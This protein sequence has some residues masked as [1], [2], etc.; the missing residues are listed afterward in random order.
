VDV[1]TVFFNNA[2]DHRLRALFPAEFAVDHYYAEG[3]FDVVKR[4]L[5]IPSGEGWIEKPVAQKPV[6]SFVALDGT[7]AGIAI[8]NQGLPEYEIIKGEPCVVAQTLLRCVGWLSRSDHEARPYNAG[9]VMPTPDAQCLGKHVFRYAVLP[10][11]GN[12]R[13][14]QVWRMA[15]QHNTPPRAVLT[16]LHK[17]DLPKSKSCVTV[18]PQNLVVTTVKKAEKSDALVVRVFNTTPDDVRASVSIGRKFKSAVL[19]NLNEEPLETKPEVQE[20]TVKFNMP[21]FRV[22][23]VMFN[24]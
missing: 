10:Y 12:W 1:L 7:D 3:Q 6:Q 9:P 4:P 19:A 14:S 22:Q 8:I 23:T 2:K 13:R 20:Q 24:L 15:H 21:G 17:G 11:V 18:S 16:G 5:D